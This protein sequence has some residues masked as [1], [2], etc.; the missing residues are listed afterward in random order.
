MHAP[1]A[2]AASACITILVLHGMLTAFYA[3]RAVYALRPCRF[4]QQ[5]HGSSLARWLLSQAS[6]IQHPVS[7]DPC[8]V[9][10]QVDISEV[11]QVGDSAADPAFVVPWNSGLRLIQQWGLAYGLPSSAVEGLP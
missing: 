2:A 5:V 10:V 1:H 9:L 11:K 8:I 3:A 7:G 4:H 6:L